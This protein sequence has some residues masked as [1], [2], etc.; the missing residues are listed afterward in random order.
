[1]MMAAIGSTTV[2]A[3]RGTVQLPRKFVAVIQR[4]GTPGTG[5]L[6]GAERGPESEIETVNIIATEA[7]AITQQTAYEAL[8]GTVTAITDSLGQTYTNALVV[9]VT[10]A[11]VAVSGVG[12]DTHSLSCSWR[13]IVEENAP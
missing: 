4:P 8:V 3:W 9:G 6:V 1:M 13:F 10:S 5:F 11:I 12:A 7:A 2:D